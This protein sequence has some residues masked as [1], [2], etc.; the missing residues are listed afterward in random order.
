LPIANVCLQHKSTFEVH[1]RT[2]SPGQL[3]PRVAGL[4]GRRW[5]TKFDP[6]P[7]L[8]YAS[9]TCYLIEVV[10][11]VHCRHH[12]ALGPDQVD[13][14]E[15]IA[16]RR[17]LTNTHSTIPTVIRQQTEA[18]QSAVNSFVVSRT[19]YCNCLPVGCPRYQLDRL[20]AVMNTA[21]RLIF[22]VGKYDGIKLLLRGRLLWLPVPKRIQFELCLLV[23]KA[24]N[25]FTPPYLS[26]LC[27]PMST[28]LSRR[29]LRSAGRGDLVIDTSISD[30]GQH[31]FSVAAPKTWNE[32]PDSLPSIRTVDFFKS[33]FKTFLFNSQTSTN[34][35][36]T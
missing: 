30:F 22:R 7:C 32:L 1:Y 2:G 8:P 20:Q 11:D 10:V 17:I 36:S 14:F 4:P 19:V 26:E 13:S 34:D 5:V 23:I 35:L 28:V 16:G 29:R 18:A 3:G 33:A 15:R 25:G 6:V 31:S 27:R 12:D 21:A 9:L 24:V